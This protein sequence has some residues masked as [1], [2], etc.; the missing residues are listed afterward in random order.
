MEPE[1]PKLFIR[2]DF[3]IIT[4]TTLKEHFSEY[5]KIKDVLIIAQKNIGFV[6]FS[7]PS[8][9]Q[10]ALKQEHVILDQRVDVEPAK[11]KVPISDRKIFVG[12]LPHAI[13][14]EEFN[15]YFNKYGTITDSIIMYNSAT[16]VK[17]GY[18]FVTYDSKEAVT[19]VLQNKFHQL[20]D[21]MVEVKKAIPKY[22]MGAEPDG[23]EHNQRCGIVN[24]YDV[25]SQPYFNPPTYCGSGFEH[26]QSYDTIS[27]YDVNSQPYFN[28]ASYWDS[29]Y[30][31]VYYQPWYDFY[32][33]YYLQP[34]YLDHPFPC[35]DPSNCQHPYC[36]NNRM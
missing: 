11:P 22:H 7:D 16:G 6:T 9:A 5:G 3:S 17:K 28:P 8:M 26:S 2:G 31:P 24:I 23:F 36:K 19:R 14:D 4:E 32:G 13:T 35:A 18:G 25:N 21:K 30:G 20:Q 33:G 10:N 29:Y 12:G 15:Q 1:N 34:M 27:I